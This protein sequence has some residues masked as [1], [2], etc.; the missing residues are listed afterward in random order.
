M[1]VLV[2][3]VATRERSHQ[4]QHSCTIN[5]TKTIIPPPHPLLKKEQ[6]THRRWRMVKKYSQYYISVTSLFSNTDIYRD[7]SEPTQRREKEST[8]LSAA[9]KSPHSASKQHLYAETK[10]RTQTLQGYNTNC[11]AQNKVT[12][13]GHLLKVTQTTG[14]EVD[15]TIK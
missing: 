5:E 9:S 14:A 13:I 2:H 15:N 7:V 10:R 8:P 11:Y 6:F 12:I 3:K 4:I 1:L